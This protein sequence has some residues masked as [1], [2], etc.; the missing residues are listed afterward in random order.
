MFWQTVGGFV[1]S[2]WLDIA[3]GILILIAWGGLSKRAYD[4]RGLLIRDPKLRPSKKGWWIFFGIVL[5]LA[6]AR[7]LHYFPAV[8]AN[9]PNAQSG[10]DS[11]EQ[12]DSFWSH[13]PYLKIIFLLI[14]IGVHS[15]LFY[16]ANK[17]DRIT[18]PKF[19]AHG[20]WGTVSWILGVSL[21]IFSS[22]KFWY[23]SV[24]LVLVGLALRHSYTTENQVRRQITFFGQWL[25]EKPSWSPDFIW[26]Y[27]LRQGCLESGLSFMLIPF[28]FPGLDFVKIVHA[29]RQLGTKKEPLVSR[30]M[31]C[32]AVPEGNKDPNA[33]KVGAAVT[34]EYMIT[35]L[36][37]CNTKAIKSLY[38]L[39]NIDPDEA[40][41]NMVEAKFVEFISKDTLEEHLLRKGNG[42]YRAALKKEMD[43]VAKEILKKWG[44]GFT[45]VELIDINPPADYEA[46]IAAAKTAEQEVLATR[47]KALAEQISIE[48]PANAIKAIMEEPAGREA[49]A[50]LIELRRS[51]KAT[52]DR[53]I[54]IGNPA[55]ALAAARK[56]TDDKK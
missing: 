31:N 38:G 26:W 19:Y 48:T 11:G 43:Q 17:N 33:S 22:L 54:V 1:D 36:T 52:H 41:V 15:L 29:K 4:E 16:L 23:V 3:I 35:R 8:Q 21:I 18:G 44:D 50:S 56:L 47:Q 49:I 37:G 5:L 27:G 55:D 32:R 6:V 39:Q 51:G 25:V 28:D 9:L 24:P 40:V 42:A 2:H 14:G 46:A 53:T 10:H 30:K 12:R 7:V 34:I 20:F 13:L 45:E